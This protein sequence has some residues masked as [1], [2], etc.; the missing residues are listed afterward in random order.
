MSLVLALPFSEGKLRV[1]VD[2][3]ARQVVPDDLVDVVEVHL[4]QLLWFLF[5][6]DSERRGA[7]F[8]P[9]PF[10]RFKA[11]WAGAR[12][13]LSGVQAMG[14]REGRLGGGWLGHGGRGGAGGRVQSSRRETSRCLLDNGHMRDRRWLWH[15]EALGEWRGRQVVQFGAAAGRGSR[16]DWGRFGSQSLGR[17]SRETTAAHD[18]RPE[19]R[20]HHG[21]QDLLRE[22]RLLVERQ[23]GADQRP[24]VVVMGLGF[25]GGNARRDVGEVL[26]LAAFP[27]AVADVEVDMNRS[28]ESLVSIRRDFNHECVRL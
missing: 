27:F 19:V 8:V 12:D 5:D 26:A 20:G 7:A 25:Y 14:R 11:N 1:A 6:A 23:R 17:T 15:R 10:T 9:G 16:R 2:G 3:D 18:T 21:R 13:R 24:V 22:V 4:V 28:G